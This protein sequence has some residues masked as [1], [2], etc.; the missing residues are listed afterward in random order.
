M[1]KKRREITQSE[2]R[3]LCREYA[4]KQ[5]AI[6]KDD[7]VRLG[8]F[9]DWDKSYASLIKNFEG[10]AINGFAEFFITGMLKKVSSQ[11]TG[12]LNVVPH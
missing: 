2:F 7:F 10:D 11:S 12:V 9:G 5:I 3:D 8:V 4:K 1:G 6:Q